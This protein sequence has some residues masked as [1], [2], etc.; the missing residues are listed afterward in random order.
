VLI[1]LL[2]LTSI[3]VAV[4]GIDMG[5]MAVFGALLLATLKSALVLWHFMHLKYESMVI[6][7]MVVLVL[8]VFLAVLVITFLDY[9]F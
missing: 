6:R 4:T 1:A 3:S 8:F 5:R 2:I 7:L 9:G